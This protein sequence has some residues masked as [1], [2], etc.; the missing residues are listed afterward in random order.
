[1]D[2]VGRLYAMKDHVHDGDDIGQRLLLLAVKG[3]RLQCFEIAG[4]QTGKALH[5]VE[6]FTQ[7]AR[8][9]A[10][11]IVDAF[12]NL[13]FYHLNHGADQRARSVI[14]TAV[15]SGVTHVLDLGFVEVGQFMFLCL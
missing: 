9:A 1:M 15:A 3:A 12:A 6:G 5:V 13:G 2:D 7:E 14:F 8:R 10:G 11:S 4:G